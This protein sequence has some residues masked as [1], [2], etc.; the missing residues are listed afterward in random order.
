MFSNLNEFQTQKLIALVGDCQDRKTIYNAIVA[1]VDELEAQ[2]KAHPAAC[3]RNGI[4][5]PDWSQDEAYEVDG[6]IYTYNMW[7]SIW[8][9]F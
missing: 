5:S 4:Y 3:K 1:K 2:L 6:M 7:R 8:A 9:R